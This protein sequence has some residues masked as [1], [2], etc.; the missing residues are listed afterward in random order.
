MI[1]LWLMFVLG[2]L[3]YF[4]Q[5]YSNRK[6]KTS[7]DFKFWFKDN[8]NELLIAF[9]FDLAAMIILLDP[10]TS[11]DVSQLEWMPAYLILPIK[12]VASFLIGYGGGW[13]IYAVFQKKIK[14]VK[15]DK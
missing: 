13:A 15:E 8:W 3:G 5:R 10:E 4:L 9:I 7:F 14:Y 2:T 1:K 12:L 11:I 6:D